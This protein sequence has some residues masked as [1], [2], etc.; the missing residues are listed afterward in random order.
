MRK[1]GFKSAR[2]APKPPKPGPA[3]RKVLKR[4]DGRVLRVNDQDFKPEN[5][6]PEQQPD[7]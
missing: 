3:V 6:Q 5:E 1:R 4:F 7:S 2:N